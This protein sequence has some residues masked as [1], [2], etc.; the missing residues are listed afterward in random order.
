MV[1]QNREQFFKIL[2]KYKN[3]NFVIT[4]M[5]GEIFSKNKIKYKNLFR[6]NNIYIAFKNN[7]LFLFY[8]SFIKSYYINIK[9]KRKEEI[10]GKKSH[11]KKIILPLFI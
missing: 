11:L 4:R 2:L 8:T 6:K 9:R 5:F 3:D 7:V 10:E 1:Y